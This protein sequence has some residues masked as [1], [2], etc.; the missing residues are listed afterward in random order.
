MSQSSPISVQKLKEAM[1]PLVGDPRFRDFMGVIDELK[2]EA[3][4]FAVSHESV[5]DERVCT[6]ALGE[7]RTYKNILA[8]Y[9]SYQDQARQE[10]NRLDAAR[11]QVEA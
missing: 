8:I 10:R 11:Q 6:A 9:A 7:V 3:M 2:E 5:K 4:E 1:L